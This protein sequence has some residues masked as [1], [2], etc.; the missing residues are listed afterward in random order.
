LSAAGN[1]FVQNHRRGQYA[2]TVDM[3]L[4]DRV[5]AAFTEFAPCL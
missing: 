1:A 5:R 2:L 4:H 3:P